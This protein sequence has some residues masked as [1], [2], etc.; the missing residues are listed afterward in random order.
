MEETE[1]RVEVAGGR[2]PKPGLLHQAESVNKRNQ[3]RTAK[4][5]VR[6]SREM[7]G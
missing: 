2:Q 7:L 6:G 3:R 1:I 4:G 5:Q